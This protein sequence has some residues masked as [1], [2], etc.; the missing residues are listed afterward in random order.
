MVAASMNTLEFRLRENNT[1]SYPVGIALMRRV[2][3]TWIYDDEDPFKLLAFE[4]PLNE[5]KQRLASDPRYFE[6][7]IQTHLLDNVHRTTL[8]L[9]P[10]PEAGRRFD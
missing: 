6:K 10:D 4:A 3:T 5:I 9:K 8:R 7:L 2:L 1:G